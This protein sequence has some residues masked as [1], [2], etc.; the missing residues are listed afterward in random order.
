MS[1][2]QVSIQEIQDARASQPT[3]VFVVPKKVNP[4]SSTKRYVDRFSDKKI[5]E[6][7][8]PYGYI[9]H[10]RSDDAGAVLVLCDSC[11]II[12]DDFS[13]MTEPTVS[14]FTNNPEFDF[15][16][17]SALCEQANITPSQ[18]ISDRLEDE[19]FGQMPYYVEKKKAFTDNNLRNISRN[20]K[21]G[22]LLR[23]ATQKQTHRENF[24]S[25]NKTFG[26]TEPEKIADTLARVIPGR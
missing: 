17:F 23:P 18:A 8:A 11:Q 4:E 19:V 5:A 26:S 25:L 1:V 20:K 13:V 9:T 21:Y 16:E 14:L 7:F 10:E 6:F 2:S 15:A 24:A 3:Q 12:F 22:K